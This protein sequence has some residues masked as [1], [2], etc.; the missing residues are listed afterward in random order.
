MTTKTTYSA[1]RIARAVVDD[2]NSAR[3][4]LSATLDRDV[5]QEETIKIASRLVT[6][7]LSTPDGNLLDEIKAHAA[8][9]GE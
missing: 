5:T 7:G 3:R 4:L 8:S 2:L 1:V 6:S 9:L